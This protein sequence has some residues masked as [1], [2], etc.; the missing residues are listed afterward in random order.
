MSS[1]HLTQKESRNILKFPFSKYYL[2]EKRNVSVQEEIQITLY[3]AL[4]ILAKRKR[5][6]QSYLSWDVFFS[7]NTIAAKS[8]F[9]I[10]SFLPSNVS[11][12]FSLLL[13]I[14]TDFTLSEQHVHIQAVIVTM[15][16]AIVKTPFSFCSHSYRLYDKASKVKLQLL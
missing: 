16:F 1:E 15:L 14:S 10:S 5:H 9:F 7:T 2:K 8:Q 11:F 3:V 4:N 12:S 6:S 13:S